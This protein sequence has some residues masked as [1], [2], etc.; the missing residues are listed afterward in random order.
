[1]LINTGGAKSD[2]RQVLVVGVYIEAGHPYRALSCF[3]DATLELD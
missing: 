1:M 2:S 3:Y